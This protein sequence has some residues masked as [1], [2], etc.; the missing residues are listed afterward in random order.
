VL[1]SNHV[2]QRY[3]SALKTAAF[4]PDMA[5]SIH[6]ILEMPSGWVRKTE[7]IDGNILFKHGHLDKKNIQT[8]VLKDIPKRHGRNY[9]LVVGHHHSEMGYGGAP[10]WRGA[11]CYWSC[12][13]GCLVDKNH[14]FM[15]YSR[16]YE[17]LGALVII[18]GWPRPVPME[19]DEAGRWT[20]NLI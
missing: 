18:D 3:K 5:R 6:E 16:G 17:V 4:L 14:P 8:V 19:C 11:D 9:S 20:G 15:S 12:F 7:H 1:E 2:D 10:H 13:T